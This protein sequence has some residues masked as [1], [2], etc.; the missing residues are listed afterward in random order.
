MGFSKVTNLLSGKISLCF[1]MIVAT[2]MGQADESRRSSV[3]LPK[4]S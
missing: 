4:S 2:N 1:S 3:T